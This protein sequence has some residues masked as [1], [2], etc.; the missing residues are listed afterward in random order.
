MDGVAGM[1]VVIRILV[2]LETSTMFEW[3]SFVFDMD[4]YLSFLVSE[5]RENLSI[6][7]MAITGSLDLEPGASAGAQALTPIRVYI[8][9]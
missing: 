6:M 3:N 9:T 7:I 2:L 5:S 4:H 1:I 8:T